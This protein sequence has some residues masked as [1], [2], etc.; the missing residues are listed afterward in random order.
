MLQNRLTRLKAKLYYNHPLAAYSSWRIGG[1]AE[2]F[3]RPKDL[4]DLAFLLCSWPEEPI[5]FLGAATNVLISS[6]GVKGLVIYLGERLDELS[7]LDQTNL[8]VGAGA[9]LVD[10]VQKCADLG[11]V[12]AAFMSG[13]PGTIGGALKMNAG[14]YGDRIWNYVVAVESINRQGEVNLRHPSDFKIGYRQV[15]AAHNG[16]WFV[17]AQLSFAPGDV[18]LAKEL[19]ENYL[20]K[21]KQAHPLDLPNCGSVFRNPEGNYAA[22]LIETCDLKGRQIG[23]ARVSEK[24]ANFIVNCGGA[25]SNEVKTLMAEIIAK[26]EKVT[27]VKLVPEVHILE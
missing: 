12:G 5:T 15:D 6:K 19:V 10:L 27:K 17:G 16:E 3:Y 21:R 7:Q 14:A 1:P 8:K 20:K 13:I 23:G 18:G 25:T 2:Y 9:K 11:M 22:K 24:H 26:V 4:E